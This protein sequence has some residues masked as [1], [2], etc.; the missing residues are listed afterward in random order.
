MGLAAIPSPDSGEIHLGPLTLH[1]YGVMYAIG[2]LAAVALTSRLW[3]R[4]GGRRELVHEVALWAFPAGLIGARLSFLAT[5]WNEVPE[6]W[7]G[8]LAVWKGGL[9]IWGGIALGTL[10]GVWRLRRAGADVAAFM[11][12][13]APGL[14]IAQAIGRIGNYFNQELFGGP[15]QL[16][17]A[18]EIDA[19]HRPAGYEAFATFHP[20]FLYELLFNLVLAGVLLMLLRRGRVRPPGIFALYVTGYSGF[21]IVE[22]TLRIDPSHHVLGL[23]LN[24]FVAVA[25]CLAGALWFIRTQWGA[26][27]LRR[28]ATLIAIGATAAA[29]GACGQVSPPPAAAASVNIPSQRAS[30]RGDVDMHHD[31]RSARRSEVLTWG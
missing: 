21:R 19:A 6:H 16:P 23:R 12:V 17:W 3:E 30:T 18:L 2:V 4:C 11:D 10:V 20:T 27:V 25:L 14:L 5:S 15:T 7:W 13:A 9:S 22:E 24:F 31:D 29:L 8:P 28:G 26:G 1:V